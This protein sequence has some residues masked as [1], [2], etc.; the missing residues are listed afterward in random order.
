MARVDF[1]DMINFTEEVVERRKLFEGVEL[2][3]LE[4]YL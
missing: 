4:S 2:E 3:P 1:K